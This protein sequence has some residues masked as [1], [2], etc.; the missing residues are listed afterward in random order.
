MFGMRALITGITGM[1]GS[2]LADFLLSK[3]YEVFGLVRR[4]SNPTY[5]N[6]EHILDDVTLIFGDLT[7][8]N[9]LRRAL[10]ASEP[11]EVYNLAA[12]SFVGQSW[13]IPEY[14]SDVTGLGALRMLEAIRE[15]DT[16]IKF[17]QA[18]SSEMFGNNRGFLDETSEM[19]PRSPYGIA[20]LYAHW[21]TKNYREAHNIYAVSGILFNHE[22]ER[23]GLEFVTRKIT[24]GVA[25][26]RLG[27]ANTLTLGTLETARDWGYAPDY[28][29]GMWLMLQQDEP[30]DYVLA[31]GQTHT[32][33][34]FVE[35]AF[36]H[37]GLNWEDHVLQDERFMRPAEVD[38]LWGNAA[39][40]REQLGWEPTTT[41]EELVARMVDSDLES[42]KAGMP[43]RVINEV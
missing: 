25:R 8:Q 28:V 17:Y 11:D 38:H 24:D 35:A 40:A 12:Q 37:V 39:K 23:R 16:K 34:Q 22:S 3:G 21:V 10:E 42:L 20:K 32:V 29:E 43:H 14:T 1:D 5:T 36:E 27:L 33:Q 41:F 15:Y 13:N 4:S 30:E 26:I 6:I 18:S 9:S 31:T 2:H 19:Y 7:D